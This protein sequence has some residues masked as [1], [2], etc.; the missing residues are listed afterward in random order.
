M[1]GRT[2]HHYIRCIK[3]SDKNT[4]MPCE[5]CGSL[6]SV[7]MSE[8]ELFCLNCQGENM[9]EQSE[10]EDIAYQIRE[11]VLTD[12]ALIDLLE[13]YGRGNL[14]VYLLTRLN[15]LSKNKLENQYT[16]AKELTNITYLITKLFERDE[17][18][19]EQ[20]LEDHTELPEE[21]QVQ[22]N[23]QARLVGSLEDMKQKFKVAVRN[24]EQPGDWQDFLN[25]H[26]FYDTE[27]KLCYLRCAESIMA[28]DPD[29]MDTYNEVCRNFRSFERTDA[30]DI[31]TVGEFADAFYEYIMEWKFLGSNRDRYEDIYTTWLPDSVDILQLR[32][33]LN[34]LDE[35]YER[36]QHAGMWEEGLAA[37]AGTNE[38]NRCGRDVFS[39]EWSAVKE[40]LIMRDDNQEAHPFLFAVTATEERQFSEGRPP[41]E[42]EVE[43]IIYPRF[44]ARLLHYQIFPMLQNADESSSHDILKEVTARRGSEFERNIYEFLD[45]KGLE[46]Y[47]SAKIT[48]NNPN[49][50]DII[51]RWEDTLYF[52]EIKYIMPRLKTNSLEGVEELNSV[53]NFKIFKEATGY[54]QE[55]G[56]EPEGKPLKQ[57]FKNWKDLE[58]SDEFS[59]QVGRD[60]EDRERTEVEEDWANLDKEVIVIS[61]AVP[62]YIEKDGIRFL[63]DFEFYQMIEED[64]N[65]FYTT[66]T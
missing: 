5:N 47:H 17:L 9:V 16:S 50:L 33:L 61:N 22:I 32:E 39:S 53:F 10:L 24:R 43:R 45:Q 19:D 2:E 11:N 36:E 66:S 62:S 57:K 42:Y 64:E 56:I 59:I 4:V 63:T 37:I 38:I 21:I 23:A 20:E 31:E 55:E 8:R 41:V 60:E 26:D 3:L 7:D 28:G 14:I 12:D 35:L 51:F 6:L 15:Y 52:V 1:W 58:P 54:Y 13:D 49:E 30:E 65:V 34:N 40:N 46:C 48:R 44:Y 27:Y 25:H 29:K 18:G